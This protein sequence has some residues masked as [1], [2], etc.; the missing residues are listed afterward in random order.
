[1]NKWIM[2]IVGVAASFFFI[3]MAVKNIR[4]NGEGGVDNN[5]KPALTVKSKTRE[6]NQTITA[7]SEVK[8]AGKF[9]QSFFKN[10]RYERYK[11]MHAQT[12]HSRPSDTFIRLI[13][14]TPI[15]WKNARILSQVSN[16]DDWDVLLSVDITDTVS[17]FAGCMVNINTSPDPDPNKSAYRFS[18]E[19]LGI[20]KFM[21]VRQEWRVVKLDNTMAI[22]IGAGASPIKRHSNIM[23]YVLDAG[24]IN[25][26]PSGDE[27]L[28]EKQKYNATIE[29]LATVFVNLDIP[30]AKTGEVIISAKPLSLQGVRRLGELVKTMRENEQNTP[31]VPSTF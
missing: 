30:V 13:S 15:R 20:E 16:G 17:A 19:F 7:N 22:D 1:M 25:V 8:E 24:Y 23:N 26:P 2:G 31:A 12:V 6:P 11:E 14:Q 29:W 21:T 18:P 10:W 9:V 27:G 5:D 3:S 4:S 28:N